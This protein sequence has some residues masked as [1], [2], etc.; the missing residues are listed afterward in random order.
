MK[1]NDKGI[2]IKLKIIAPNINIFL[3]YLEITIGGPKAFKGS[4]LLF[5]YSNCNQLHP[6]LSISKWPSHKRGRLSFTN[7]LILTA[8]DA[9]SLCF[10]PILLANKISK[11]ES[12]FNVFFLVQVKLSHQTEAKYLEPIIKMDIRFPSCA[13]CSKVRKL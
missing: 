11:L 12:F 7:K 2:Y 1:H 8:V 9:Y 13:N 6:L 10:L 4:V 3:F 5:F